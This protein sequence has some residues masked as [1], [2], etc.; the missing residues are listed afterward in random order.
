M[1]VLSALLTLIVALNVE[2]V[3]EYMSRRGRVVP[4]SFVIGSGKNILWSRELGSQSY[5]GPVVANGKIF[6]G[7]NNTSAYLTRYPKA[8]D[9]GVLLCFD[10]NDG[11]FLWQASSEK[12]PTGRVH[13][14]PLQGVTSTP[15]V[16]QDRLY[17]VN[18]R[19]E[20]V[21]LDTEGFHRGV[22]MLRYDGMPVPELPEE[23][24][25]VL[26]VVNFDEL[27]NHLPTDTPQLTPQERRA[28]TCQ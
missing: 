9:L 7:T 3:R 6:V 17:Y 20:L 12:L 27:R 22:V 14:W 26:T 10:A 23:Q 24:L 8:V 4:T 21:C 11:T 19:C 2:R 5:G 16:D 1:L 28:D 15:A 18:N 13:D 25:P